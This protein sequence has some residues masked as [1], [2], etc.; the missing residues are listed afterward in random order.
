MQLVKFWEFFF[1]IV[2]EV[3]GNLGKKKDKNKAHMFNQWQ[4]EKRKMPKFLPL[5][6]ISD[7]SS[8]KIFKK[9]KDEN[10]HIVA[11]FAYT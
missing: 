1:L 10:Y 9:K 4:K 7:T 5:H 3:L 11:V 2:S 8:L 6:Q